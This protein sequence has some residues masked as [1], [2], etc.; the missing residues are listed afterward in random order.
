MCAHMQREIMCTHMHVHICRER[1]CVHRCMYAHMQ[2]A[3]VCTHECIHIQRERLSWYRRPLS[4]WTVA[5]SSLTTI[6]SWKARLTQL[7]LK[8]LCFNLVSHADMV[9]GISHITS[10]PRVTLGH[11]LQPKQRVIPVSIAGIQFL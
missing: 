9:R 5:K 4:S 7:P 10:T 1:S 2:R 8:P 6:G 3:H 11:I